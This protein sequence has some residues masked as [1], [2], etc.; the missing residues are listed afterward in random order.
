MQFSELTN[1]GQ[2]KQNLPICI[3]D[4]FGCLILRLSKTEVIE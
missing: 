4:G 3:F 2:E 1:A